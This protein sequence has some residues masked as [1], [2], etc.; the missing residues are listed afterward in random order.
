MVR[1][2]GGNECNLRHLIMFVYNKNLGMRLVYGGRYYVRELGG[3][4]ITLG[5]VECA[6][7][8]D[9]WVYKMNYS[10]PRKSGVGVDDG[11][12]RVGK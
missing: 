4:M 6:C 10:R 12:S 2:M 5:E 9:G 3:L 11:G 7:G 1:C 8:C